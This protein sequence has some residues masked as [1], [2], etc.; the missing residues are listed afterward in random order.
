MHAIGSTFGGVIRAETKGDFCRIRVNLD[1]QKQLRRGIFICPNGKGKIWLPFKYEN[2]P[3]FCFGC[4]RMGHEVKECMEKQLSDS[5]KAGDEYT[6]SLTLRAESFVV[7]KESMIFGELL[8]KSM[9]QYIYTG[10]KE[11]SMDVGSLEAA[12]L[13]HWLE[14][15][16]GPKNS[17]LWAT[18]KSKENSAKNNE[19]I[20]PQISHRRREESSG[21]GEGINL[22]QISPEKEE[23]NSIEIRHT[24]EDVLK[25]NFE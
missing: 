13:V 9:K 15:K 4:G 8:K 23:E 25:D 24:T 16:I 22:P 6:F 14:N 18:K 12:N 17:V 19:E 1:V 3:T 21:D 11:T 20:S 10:K 5:N 7:R 2:L